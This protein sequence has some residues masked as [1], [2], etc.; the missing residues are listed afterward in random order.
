MEKLTEL[1]D[2]DQIKT[3]YEFQ[4]DK[5]L[6]QQLYKANAFRMEIYQELWEEAFNGMLKYLYEKAKGDFYITI[7]V[8]KMFCNI[9]IP[10]AKELVPLKFYVDQLVQMIFELRIKLYELKM[11]SMC[12]IKMPITQNTDIV[13]R[14]KNIYNMHIII[15]NL[16]GDKL[17]YDQYIFIYNAIKFVFDSTQRD[18]LLHLKDDTFIKDAIP[19]HVILCALVRM[20]NIIE[21]LREKAKEI[22]EEFSYDNYL[23]I[24]MPL[25]PT[26]SPILN[27]YDA[28]TF[29]L[30][31]ETRKAREVLQEEIDQIGRFWLMEG[32]VDPESKKLWIEAAEA[33]RNIN[34]SVQQDIR[35]MLL[36]QFDES[37]KITNEKS[38]DGLKTKN[39]ESR[40]NLR[41]LSSQKSLENNKKSNRSSSGK[42]KM[43]K[44]GI[45][46]KK[47]VV[48]DEKLDQ[49]YETD[50][51][52]ILK[53][54]K[55]K[56][57]NLDYFR[58]PFCWNF[59]YEKL[60]KNSEEERI[61]LRSNDPRQFYKDG[62]V[63]KFLDKLN[64]IKKKMIEYKG[65]VWDYLIGKIL[66]IMVY[67]NNANILP[68]KIG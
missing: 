41:K 65:G 21:K 16:M 10:K 36:T 58:P 14:I 2:R 24:N 20:T 6:E 49:S 63:E 28:S 43:E 26:D 64:E 29:R 50:D 15:E 8:H 25:E 48:K 27:A 35:D 51:D 68:S 33:L 53:K 1:L 60:K 47:Q 22:G 30:T 67:L 4:V 45:G 61:E 55:A 23:Q 13:E 3:E 52:S 34:Y 11:N 17:K 59:P 66:P 32:F 7:D 9:D 57:L 54:N 37:K 46:K 39:K 44:S 5:K 42:K 19:K 18:Y 40:D 62:R 31:D 12:R 56:E 38:L